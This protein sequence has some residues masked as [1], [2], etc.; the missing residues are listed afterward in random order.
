MCVCVLVCTI[1]VAFFSQH[2]MPCLMGQMFEG[3]GE[4]EEEFEDEDD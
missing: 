4:R 3:E 2:L 1:A